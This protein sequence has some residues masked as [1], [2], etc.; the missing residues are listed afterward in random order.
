MILF[1]S[2]PCFCL[3]NLLITAWDNWWTVCIVTCIKTINDSVYIYLWTTD[4]IVICIKAISNCVYMY[5]W[6]VCIVICI[7]AVVL[8]TLYTCIHGLNVLWFYQKCHDCV[9]MSTNVNVIHIV[10]LCRV[11]WISAGKKGKCRT[12]PKCICVTREYSVLGRFCA[13]VVWAV[14]HMFMNTVTAILE[15][16]APCGITHPS[17]TLSTYPTPL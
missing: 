16:P 2:S 14:R 6:T 11:W 9:F 15:Y 17:F 4:C 13:F 10:E 5:S 8:M 12:E 1:P 3:H 7:K